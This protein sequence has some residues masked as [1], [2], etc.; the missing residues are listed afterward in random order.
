MFPLKSR[1]ER[2]RGAFIQFYFKLCY[3]WNIC[4]F[5]YTQKILGLF[6][7]RNRVVE[8]EAVTCVLTSQNLFDTLRGLMHPEYN[9]EPDFWTEATVLEISRTDRCLATL[10]APMPRNREQNIKLSYLL[11]F[12]WLRG[13]CDNL[14]YE[15]IWG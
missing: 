10:I 9:I 6:W 15:G 3:Y 2:K 14:G 1:S 4:A 5:T 11:G 7:V 13:L 8:C 12:L